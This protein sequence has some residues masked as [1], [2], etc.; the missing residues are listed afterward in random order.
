MIAVQDLTLRLDGAQQVV[1]RDAFL[2]P[3]CGSIGIFGESGFTS[4]ERPGWFRC[5]SCQYVFG[6]KLPRIVHAAGVVYE[7][8]S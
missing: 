2:C 1:S 4:T 8:G 5:E 6:I 3:M 7:F